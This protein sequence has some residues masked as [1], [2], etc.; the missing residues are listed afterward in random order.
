MFLQH[1]SIS[2]KKLQ[3]EEYSQL[4]LRHGMTLS[5]PSSP[6]TASSTCSAPQLARDPYTIAT[7][8]TGPQCGDSSIYCG[9][10]HL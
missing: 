1:L 5:H 8:I 10:S 6:F 7:H 4:L 3:G 9:V 2:R